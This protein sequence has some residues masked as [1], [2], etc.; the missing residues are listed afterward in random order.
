MWMEE[1]SGQNKIKANIIGNASSN[2]LC[3]LADVSECVY[4]TNHYDTTIQK[5]A[6]HNHTENDVHT[7]NNRYKQK[8]MLSMHCAK[9]PTL[10]SY[11]KTCMYG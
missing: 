9:K 2:S 1:T 10:L 5:T 11:G 7:Q 4:F 6:A 8:S 3:G